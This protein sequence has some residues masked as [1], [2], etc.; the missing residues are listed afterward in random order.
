MSDQLTTERLRELAA[1][2]T[3]YV[4]ERNAIAA[5]LLAKREECASLWAS[6]R[7]LLDSSRKLLAERDAARAEAKKYHDALVARHGG[8]PIAL[9]SELDEARAEAEKL[10]ADLQAMTVEAMRAGRE[11]DAVKR[12]RDELVAAADQVADALRD[13][14]G[15]GHLAYLDAFDAAAAACAASQPAQ[16]PKPPTAIDAVAEEREKQRRKWGSRHDAGHDRGE[17]LNAACG[18]M[19]ICRGMHA[20]DRWGIASRNQSRRERLVIAAALVVAEI[21]R[22]DAEQPKPEVQP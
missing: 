9:L 20:E 14:A 6:G 17:L 19:D 8:E 7:A 5:E 13:V 18:L 16:Q 4:H 10:R 3:I 22:G 12:Q 1:G 21:D 2:A 11:L 15:A